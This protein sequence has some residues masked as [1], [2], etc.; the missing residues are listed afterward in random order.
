[1]FIQINI[2]T[3]FFILIINLS[4][5]KYSDKMIKKLENIVIKNIIIK[6]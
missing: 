1:M 2:N 3:I 4:I 6:S 5:I